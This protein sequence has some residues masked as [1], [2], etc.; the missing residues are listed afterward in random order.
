MRHDHLIKPVNGVCLLLPLCSRK[1]P[2][3]RGGIDGTAGVGVSF[4]VTKIYAFIVLLSAYGAKP[5]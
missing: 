1:A 3:H 4:F 5:L 2:H